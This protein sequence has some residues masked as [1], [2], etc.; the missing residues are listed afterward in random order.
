ME[1]FQKRFIQAKEQSSLQWVD[2]ATH[3]G[4]D[5]ANR[6]LDLCV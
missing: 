4:L 5:K 6:P 2:I 1:T 3:S